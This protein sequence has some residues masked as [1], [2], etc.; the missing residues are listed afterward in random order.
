MAESPLH[1]AEE[2]VADASSDAAMDM[3]GLRS[4]RH[5]LADLAGAV[6]IGAI[7]ETA[8]TKKLRAAEPRVHATILEMERATKQEEFIRIIA[9]MVQAVMS[10]AITAEKIQAMMDDPTS[11]N[12]ESSDAR[13]RDAV[14]K[15]ALDL[16]RLAIQQISSMSV[17]PA[18]QT[19]PARVSSVILSECKQRC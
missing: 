16:A 19:R 11:W 15:A 18:A 13:V 3:E 8:R 1:R 2:I 12:E 7:E 10:G 14:R 5:T 6:E 9:E 17:A 4:T